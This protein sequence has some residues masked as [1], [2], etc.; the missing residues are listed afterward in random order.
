MCGQGDGKVK[1]SPDL[2]KNYA[3]NMYGKVKV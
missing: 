1:F 3:M 2:I